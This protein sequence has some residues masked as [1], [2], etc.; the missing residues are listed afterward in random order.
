MQLTKER[1]PNNINLLHCGIY[2]PGVPWL[3]QTGQAYSKSGT[4]KLH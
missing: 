1:G 4:N 3:M 2:F